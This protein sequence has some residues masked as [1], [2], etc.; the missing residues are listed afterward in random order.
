MSSSKLKLELMQDMLLLNNE[1]DMFG[2]T[3]LMHVFCTS[4]VAYNIQIVL[5]IPVH[6]W[7]YHLLHWSQAIDD[8]TSPLLHIRHMD[9]WCWFNP[10]QTGPSGH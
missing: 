8:P 4:I 5:H 2:T 9:I 6:S 1:A 10:N 7:W 3:H